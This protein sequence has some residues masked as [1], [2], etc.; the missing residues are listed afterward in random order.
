MSNNHFLKSKQ[1][2]KPKESN[3][4]FSSL[5]DDDDTNKTSFK[6]SSN[7]TN[8]KNIEYNSGANSFTKSSKPYRDNRRSNDTRTKPQEAPNSNDLNL[9][10]E[11]VDMKETTTNTV[12]SST[13]FKDILTNVIEEEKPKVNPIPPGWIQLSRVNG[14]VVSKSGDLTQHMIKMQQKE[15]L[16]QEREND[17]NHI[18]FK[19]IESMKNNWQHYEREYDEINGE[20][21]YD[22]KFILQPVYESEYETE[23]ETDTDTENDEM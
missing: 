5:D 14:K 10:P 19:A 3:N 12:E 11:L 2:Y 17:P 20:G 22:E 7:K 4:R 16:E 6:D 9:F 1:D 15:I 13:N 18:M 21:S 8:K 23:S